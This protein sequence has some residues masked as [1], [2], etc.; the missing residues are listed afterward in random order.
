M[1]S[2]VVKS[3]GAHPE[4][5]GL[6]SANQGAKTGASLGAKAGQVG[7]FTLASRLLGFLRWVV[8]A[9]TVGSGAMAGAY[10]SANQIPNVFYEVVVG[11]ALAGTVVPLLAGAIAHGQREKVRETASGLLG[12]TLAVLLP[13]AVLMAL[14]AEPLAQL[15][16]TSDTRM[17]ADKAAI[18]YWGGSHQLV[19][20]FLRMFALQIPLY[21]LGVVLTGVLQAYNRFTWPA[22]APIFSSLVVML[23]YGI[24]GA[25]IDAGHYAQ[26]VLTLGWGTTAGVAAL[27]LPLL[28]P[29]HRLGLG[30]RARLRLP[31]GTFTQ[32]RSLAGAGIAALIAQQISVLTV[33]AVAR[34]YGSAGTIAIYQYTQAIYVLP[35]A[36]LAVPLATVVYPQLAARLAA[37]HV[38]RETKDLI[39]NS[40]ALVTLAA[41]VGAG[42]LMLGAPVA[43]QVFGL[44][45]T[46]DYMGAAL[47]AFAPGLVGYALIYQLTRVLYVLDAARS[48]ALATCLGWL[49]VAGASWMFSANA[50]GAAVLVYLGAASSAGMSLA[51]VALALVLARRVGARALVPSLKIVALYLVVSAPALA[52][53]QL[54]DPTSALGIVGLLAL[55]L[56]VA[57]VIALGGVRLVPQSI[58]VLRSR[59]ALAKTEQE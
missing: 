47:V 10:S 58:K 14:F 7:T 27:S 37:K 39:A 17:G 49:V 23:T 30:L 9:A 15:L 24:Y 57:G 1:A 53:A 16:V 6:T 34:R 48:A 5:E 54:L 3:R 28:W 11:G 51:G 12:L 21:G 46:V 45:T 19:V 20:A 8:Q 38:S 35:Y 33:V 32:L 55:A 44:I 59:K 42:A 25:L 26:A 50:K 40:T 2:P 31:A 41:C 43:Q 52:L 56:A 18:V 36:V 13:L 22:L 29:V 4:D